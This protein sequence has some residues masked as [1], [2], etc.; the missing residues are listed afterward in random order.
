MMTYISILYLK[1]FCL[2]LQNIGVILEIVEILWFVI[3]LD[4]I[5]QFFYDVIRSVLGS[6]WFINNIGIC[7]H[8]ERLF[9]V[10]QRVRG[11]YLV[12]ASLEAPF[13][14][15]LASSAIFSY[16]NIEMESSFWLVVS[17]CSSTAISSYVF[18]KIHRQSLL[19]LKF[20]KKRLISRRL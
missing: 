12:H 6:L 18:G 15:V 7:H 3:M 16:R 9:P 17:T 14:L 2:F 8:R 5:G 13:G 1:D 10:I 19:Y 11:A 20:F 4:I